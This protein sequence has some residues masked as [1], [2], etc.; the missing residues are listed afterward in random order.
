MVV[1]L[2]ALVQPVQ[3]FVLVAQGLA[4]VLLLDVTVPGLGFLRGLGILVLRLLLGLGC[5]LAFV[6]GLVLDF[7][8]R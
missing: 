4:W 1:A 2:V 8:L 5:F 7:R 6:F 3:G